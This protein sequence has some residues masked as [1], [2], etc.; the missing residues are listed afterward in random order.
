MNTKRL[1]FSKKSSFW[2]WVRGCFLGICFL[3]F[4]FSTVANDTIRLTWGIGTNIGGEPILNKYIGITASNGKQFIVSWGDG[5]DSTYIGTGNK[6]SL[7]HLYGDTSTY[8]VTIAAID[9]DCRFIDLGL[10]MSEAITLDVSNCTELTEIYCRRNMLI[11]FDV[12]NCIALTYLDCSWNLLTHLD[13][14]NRTKLTVVRCN[15]NRLNNLNVDNCIALTELYCDINHF[16]GSLDVSSCIALERLRCDHNQLTLLDISKNAK[17]EYLTCSD[18]KLDSLDVSSCIALVHLV[19]VINKITHLD[20]TK[21]IHLDYLWCSDNQLSSLDVSK[22][23]ELTLLACS[24]NL[25]DSLDVSNNTKLNNFNCANNQ[26]S[27]LDVSNSTDLEYF[28]CSK[29]QLDSLDLSKNTK[30]RWLSCSFN[31]ISSLDVSN[32]TILYRLECSDNLLSSLN[33][34]TNTLRWFY[35]YNNRLSLSDLYAVSEMITD[36]DNKYLGLQMLIPQTAYIG[37]TLFSKQSV[38]NSIY[39][40]YLVRKN[41]TYAPIEDYS[42]VNGTITFNTIG[43]YR[44]TMTNDAI[45]SH[46]YYPAQVIVDINIEEA[47]SIVEIDNYSFLRVYPNPTNG[48]LTIRNE[49]SEVRN[50][51]IFDIYGRKLPLHFPSFGGAGVVLDISHLHTGLYFLKIDGKTFKIIKE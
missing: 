13:L 46:I 34:G 50:V 11:H 23:T 15:D 2:G 41:G 5:V 24:E 17:L 9:A 10:N 26:I 37:D 30:L 22:N 39:T 3:A 29:N 42:I 16:L 18:N 21:N 35:G 48:Q 27:Y 49:E 1:S 38:F 8:M 33:L 19:C 20:M 36:T 12:T 47:N 51:E 25:L 14:N 7:S 32:T 6:Q 28:T 45:V 40:D 43:N 44:V 31:K 4:S